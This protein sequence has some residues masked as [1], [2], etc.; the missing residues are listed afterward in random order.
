[1]SNKVE[2]MSA[3][4]NVID[5]VRQQVKANLAEAVN[6]GKIDIPRDQLEKVCFYVENSIT[7][8]FVKASG[9]IENAIKK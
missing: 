9:Q 7:T 4:A 1:M 6:K 5:F 8:S 3:V 2:V